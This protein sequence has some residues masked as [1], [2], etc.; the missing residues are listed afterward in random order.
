MKRFERVN[1]T[2]KEVA[3]LMGGNCASEEFIR[4]GLQQGKFP[5]GYAVKMSSRWTYWI[6]KEKFQEC[7]GI[8]VEGW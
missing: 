8:Q 4:R 1:L 7:T 3:D 5:W 6:S 2:V